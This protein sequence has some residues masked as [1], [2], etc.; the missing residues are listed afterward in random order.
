MPKPQVVAGT[1][2]DVLYHLTCLYHGELGISATPESAS[3]AAAAHLRE[4]HRDLDGVVAPAA[5]VQVVA[6]T[7]ISSAHFDAIDALAKDLG[8]TAKPQ[9]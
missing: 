3:Q 4:Q 1:I 7:H 8:V 5:D 9:S 2:G 6:I